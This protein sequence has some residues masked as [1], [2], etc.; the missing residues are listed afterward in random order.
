M[1]EIAST[2]RD[3]GLSGDFHEGAAHIMRFLAAS[4]FG[5]ETR[6]TYDRSRTAAETISRLATTI[7]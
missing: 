7:S 4:E 1:E 3:V 6:R 5:N 2:F